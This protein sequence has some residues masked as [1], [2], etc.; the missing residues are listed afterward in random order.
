MSY[1]FGTTEG[2][3][4]LRFGYSSSQRGGR[5]LHEGKIRLT[6][7]NGL[8]LGDYLQGRLPVFIVSKDTLTYKGV[9]HTT[10]CIS[11]FSIHELETFMKAV[12]TTEIWSLR[13]LADKKQQEY[14]ERWEQPQHE[15][16]FQ[17]AVEY[18]HYDEDQ[19]R[20]VEFMDEDDLPF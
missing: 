6:V 3:R 13:Q 12:Q 11:T 1:L 2:R 7:E 20:R 4:N 9:P 17:N 15:L 10:F 5:T 16:D 19:P 14:N 8:F 18:S